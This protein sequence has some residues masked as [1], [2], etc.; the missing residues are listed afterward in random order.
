MIKIYHNPRC[1]KSRQGLKLLEDS[2]QPF[3]VIKYLDNPLTTKELKD[4]LSLLD[5][6]PI[7]LVRK[8]EAIWKENYKDKTL[9]DAQVIEA[10]INNPKLIERPIV[11]NKNKAVVGRP[12]EKI[13]T[14]L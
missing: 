14:I 7:D 1:S 12:T 5:I 2:N 4:I 8:T 13:T 10:L 11:T 3:E 9:I 6:K